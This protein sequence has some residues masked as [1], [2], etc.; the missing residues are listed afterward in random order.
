MDFEGLQERLERLDAVGSLGFVAEGADFF[1]SLFEDLDG[2]VDPVVVC[3]L[4]CL[5]HS[6][7]GAL[8]GD[9]GNHILVEAYVRRV[10]R[11]EDADGLG[12]RARGQRRAGEVVPEDFKLQ[13][14]LAFKCCG[15]R[16][17]GQ[18]WQRKDIQLEGQ[19]G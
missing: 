13:E 4:G 10:L 7:A 12:V 15:G 3:G 17:V 11:W 2:L 18:Q 1:E 19:C 14:A 16:A 6:E 5:V 9:C 8:G